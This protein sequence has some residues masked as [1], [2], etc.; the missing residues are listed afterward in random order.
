MMAGPPSP[1]EAALLLPRLNRV[2]KDLLDAGRTEEALAAFTEAWDY[3][4]RLVEQDPTQHAPGLAATANNISIC[5]SEL[6]RR[7][8]TLHYTQEAVT[9]LRRLAK[10]NPAAYESDLAGCLSNLGITLAE[11]KRPDDALIP[12]RESVN[13]RSRL[14]KSDP[15]AYEPGLA[16]DLSALG[17]VLH[18]AKDLSDLGMAQSV[19]HRLEEA[20]IVVRRAV[21]LF[22]R[23]AAVEPAAYESDLARVLTG[24]AGLAQDL[25]RSAEAL[26]DSES[27]VVLCRRL[28]ASGHPVR[29]ESLAHA[30][31]TYGRV[32]ILQTV[33]VP[34]AMAA[35]SEAMSILHR[36]NEKRPHHYDGAL[37]LARAAQVGGFSKL[38]DQAAAARLLRQILLEEGVPP[39]RTDTGR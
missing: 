2:G 16:K 23:L 15:I 38:G 3:N 33:E 31:I 29:E 19:P 37:T 18:V 17:Q 27:A 21:D 34:T 24:L 36:L 35:L 22:R 14:A 4:C 26:T 9:V 28:A 5:L 13:M 11:L 32:R 8:E 25:G 1:E 6:G 7:E 12:L 20:L 30:L 10:A 39:G